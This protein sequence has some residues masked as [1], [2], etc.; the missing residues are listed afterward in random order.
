MLTVSSN[1]P[2][3]IEECCAEYL[4]YIKSVR[5]LSE[6]T[7]KGYGEDFKHFMQILTP[8]KPLKDLTLE[9]LRG[10]VGSL[11]RRK[12]GSVSINRFIAAVRGL[13]AY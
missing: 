4:L 9:D 7:V 10:C 3:S 8:Q 2:V 1:A 13:F 6:N 5:G 11:S 12:Y